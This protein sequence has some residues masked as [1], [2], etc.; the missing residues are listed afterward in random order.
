VA[1]PVHAQGRDAAAAPRKALPGRKSTEPDMGLFGFEL[2]R[3]GDDD[4]GSSFVQ[5]HWA[6]DVD[7][8]AVERT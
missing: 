5:L 2:R 4:L 7:G 1:R 8:L 6:R 3:L